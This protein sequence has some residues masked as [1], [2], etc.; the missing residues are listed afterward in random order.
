MSHNPDEKY[1]EAPDEGRIDEID[2][3]ELS[4]DTLAELRRRCDVSDKT[5][6]RIFDYVFDGTNTPSP[7][8]QH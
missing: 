4:E 3:P 2:I 6:Q 8:T 1:D 5:L 7:S